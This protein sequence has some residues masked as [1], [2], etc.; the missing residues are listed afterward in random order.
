MDRSFCAVGFP[1]LQVRLHTTLLAAFP[2][3]LLVCL[4]FRAIPPL[5]PRLA[6][7]IF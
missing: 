1:F 6:A 2:A 4:E 7:P 5:K 3:D